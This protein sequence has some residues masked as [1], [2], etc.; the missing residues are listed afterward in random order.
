MILPIVPPQQ[1]FEDRVTQLDL[2]ISKTLRLTPKIRSQW[3]LDIYNV[4]NSNAVVSVNATYTPPPS[5]SWLRPTRI[6]DAR[7]FEIGG[8]IDF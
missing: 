5:T 1:K 6:L 2:R 8:K 3:N 7:V 4:T